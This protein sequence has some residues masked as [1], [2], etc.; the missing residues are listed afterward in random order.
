[1]LELITI[2]RDIILPVFIIMTIGYILQKKFSLD[3]QTLARLNIYFVVPAFIF[4]KLSS[5]EIAFNMFIK[6]LFF[7]G[8]F[9]FILYVLSFIVAHLLKLEHGKKVTF[10]NS[11]IFFNSGNYAVPVNDLVFRGD[12]FAMSI[13]VIV[14]M[15]QNI[16]IFSYGIF[17][18]QSMSTGKLKAAF[19]YFKMPVMYAM[20]GG[21]IVNALNISVPGFIWVPAN[22]IA[23]AM[24][25]IALLTLGAQVAQL[26]LTA[27]L[28]T[29][30]FSL[31]LRLI[32]G[33]L[34]ALGMI[35]AFGISGITAQA[36]LIASSTPTAVNSAVIAQEYKNHPDLA[37]QIVLFSTLASAFTVTFFIYV[38]R[39]L[40]A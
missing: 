15:F 37:A 7:I 32:A 28:G 34:V 22:Y 13:Q 5:T 38:G 9:V 30:Y 21:L 39:L 16:F 1:M 29:V 23:N 36:L 27:G 18:L 12:P 40:F 14:L 10:T 19:A 25:A 31:V 26:K 4:V 24:I 8:L 17:S 2:L 33:P 11:I 35:F 20:I 3:V 6:V